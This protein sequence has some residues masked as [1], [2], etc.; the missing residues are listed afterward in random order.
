MAFKYDADA[1]TGSFIWTCASASAWCASGSSGL[2]S[3]AC[4][5]R[6]IASAVSPRAAKS[7]PHWYSSSYLLSLSLSRT[8]FISSSVSDGRGGISDSLFSTGFPVARAVA[9]R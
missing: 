3:M 5:Y 7:W 6:S 1:F 8:A 4:L 9:F 2:M